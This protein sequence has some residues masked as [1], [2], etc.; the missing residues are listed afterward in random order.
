MTYIAQLNI[1]KYITDDNNLMNL[2][3]Y[4]KT[5]MKKWIMSKETSNWINAYKIALNV[6]KTELCAINLL[7]L[8]HLKHKSQPTKNKT[9]L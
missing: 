2:K 9:Q 4:V 7:Y 6:S 1:A 5:I 3:V 8:D